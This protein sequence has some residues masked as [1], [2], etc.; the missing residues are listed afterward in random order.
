MAKSGPVGT[1]QPDGGGSGGSIA[2]RKALV[3]AAIETLKADGFAGSSARSIGRRA[4]CNQGLVFYHFGSVVNLLLAALDAVSS[5]RLEH[6]AAAVDAAGSPSELVEVAASVFEEDLDA[7]H[8]AVLVAMIAG[9]SSTPGLGAEV[10][11]RIAPWTDFARASVEAALGNSALTS[12][13]PAEDAAYA[14]VAMYLG[15]EMLSHL[16]G[17]RSRALALFDHA[18]A[19][20]AVLT[21]PP[22]SSDPPTPG[23]T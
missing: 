13:V 10:S 7:G 5:E 21:P 3:D 11:E 8:V 17:D 4:G 19:L 14:V 16:D 20:A 23:E 2:T 1:V 12:V 15:L 9:S 18:R 6:Y 22:E